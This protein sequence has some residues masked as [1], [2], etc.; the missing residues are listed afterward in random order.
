MA[1][2]I[3]RRGFAQAEFFLI[4]R[5]GTFRRLEHLAIKI[6]VL[7][8]HGGNA[9]IHR[10]NADAI[11]HHV[12]CRV[13]ADDHHQRQ[14]V[15]QRRLQARLQLRKHARTWDLVVLGQLQPL[16]EPH[17]A[18]LG[19]VERL[20]H[21]RQLDHRRG[22]DWFVGI[23]RHRRAGLRVLREQIDLS[24]VLRGHG[25]EVLLQIRPKSRNCQQ[26]RQNQRQA[27][28][29]HGF[30]PVKFRCRDHTA[31]AGE[32]R[33]LPLAPIHSSLLASNQ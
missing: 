27:I 5:H 26:Q 14:R 2:A 33:P 10:R 4:G 17:F 18:V 11:Q 30:A 23:D 20:D 16:I 19:L 3:S 7:Q 1:S 28:I 8:A 9:R 21:H 31:T 25:G 15:Q 32:S 29:F 22:L 6:S 12:R 13:V 24:V